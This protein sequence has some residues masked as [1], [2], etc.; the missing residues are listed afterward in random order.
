[1]VP[2]MGRCLNDLGNIDQ[3]VVDIVE[4]SYLCDI[5]ASGSHQRICSSLS[6]PW[7]FRSHVTSEESRGNFV[8][9]VR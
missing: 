8:I 7:N 5:P 3:S 4:A 6:V 9:L 2:L 1:M